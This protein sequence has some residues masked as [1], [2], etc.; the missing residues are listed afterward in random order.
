M[1]ENEISEYRVLKLMSEHGKIALQIG[2][3]FDGLAMQEG[4]ERLQRRGW[5]RLIDVSPLSS[6]PDRVFRIFLASE[7]AISWFRKQQ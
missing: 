6:Y 2:A 7:D 3:T 4:L 5:L 1:T